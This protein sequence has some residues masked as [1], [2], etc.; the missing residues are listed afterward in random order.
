MRSQ[1]GATADGL[2]A[3]RMGAKR[4]AD[5]LTRKPQTSVPEI[6]RP[7]FCGQD[8][9]LPTLFPWVAHSRHIASPRRLAPKIRRRVRVEGGV[10]CVNGIIQLVGPERLAAC[11]GSF[12]ESL[13]R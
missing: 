10:E 2:S 9:F 5:N 1:L 13:V 12:R 8:G 7:R 4:D 3:T 11:T 6:S